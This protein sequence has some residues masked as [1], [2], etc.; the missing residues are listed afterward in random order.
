MAATVGPDRFND[1]YPID[2][3][4]DIEKKWGFY[5]FDCLLRVI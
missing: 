1:G 2:S 5:S 4:Y 3:L